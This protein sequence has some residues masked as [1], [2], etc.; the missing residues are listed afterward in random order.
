MSKRLAIAGG[1]LIILALTSLCLQSFI[2]DVIIVPVIYT[3][4]SIRLFLQSVPGATYWTMLVAAAAL[5]FFISILLRMRLPDRR[6]R[7]DPPVR[8][9]VEVTAGYIR[10]A[11]KGVFSKWLLANRLVELAR[12]IMKQRGVEVFNMNDLRGTDWDPPQNIRAYFEAGANRYFMQV[13]RRRLFARLRKTP[14]EVDI[15]EVIDYLESKM[16]T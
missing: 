6:K 5:I 10:S 8:G 4:Y 14:F 3:W 2:L 16:K 1:L 12:A 11:R 15:N 13:P 9:Q 7:D